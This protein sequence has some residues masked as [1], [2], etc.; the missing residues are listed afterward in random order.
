[1]SLPLEAH[2]S[3]LMAKG[4]SGD[5]AAYRSLLT[6]L[7]RILKAFVR[8]RLGDSD[9]VEE[10]VQEILLSL[11]EARHSYDPT[12]PFRPWMFA[13]A[14]YRLADHLR[15]WAR[16]KKRE[17]EAGGFIEALS[18]AEVIPES[19]VSVELAE[20]MAA[21]PERQREAVELL[22]YRG[23]SIKEAAKQLGISEA[24]VKVRAHRAYEA[25]RTRFGVNSYGNA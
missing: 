18:F 11:H 10:V 24:S 6:E 7:S 13:I 5:Q 14:R 19:E 17:V 4:Q 2:L 25:L 20:A 12:R 23:L 1:V 15:K 8:R 21:L 16:T 3:D 9:S 22:K